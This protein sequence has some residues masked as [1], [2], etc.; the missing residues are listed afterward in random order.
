[1]KVNTGNY[2]NEQG[3]VRERKREGG[4]ENS[5]IH[6]HDKIKWRQGV[7]RERIGEKDK[8]NLL[9]LQTR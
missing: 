1:M 6:A 3:R 4:N 8:Q 9:R 5:Q 2:R 7:E